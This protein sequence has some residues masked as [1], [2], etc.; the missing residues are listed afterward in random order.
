M[1]RPSRAKKN[2]RPAQVIFDHSIQCRMS[3]QV[4]A[5]QAK[6]EAQAV[7]AKDVGVAHQESQKN[8]VAALEDAMQ[9]KEYARS[10]EN[11]RRTGKN[12]VS[13]HSSAVQAG[14]NSHSNCCKY[15]DIIFTAK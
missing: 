2:Y 12:D 10:L 6:A 14:S 3:D 11:F 7:A 1:E 5:D 8:R 13:F 15:L 4:K 9:D